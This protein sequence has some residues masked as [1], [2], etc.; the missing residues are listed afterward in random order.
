MLARVVCI[1]LVALLAAAPLPAA[2]GGGGAPK[3]KDEPNAPRKITDSPTFMQ[4]PA[5]TA[6]IVRDG[7]IRGMIFVEVG[8]DIP[9][10]G[11][12]HDAGTLTPRLRDAWT[13]AMM[14]MGM[15]ALSHQRAP[16]PAAVAATLQ[17][18]TD[19]VLGKPGAQV[20]LIH[21]YQKRRI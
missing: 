7:L 9:D 1:V 16:D 20:L 8:L 12:R 14:R 13:S 10:S 18:E 3:P 11:L 5:V 19:R 21:L 6:A 2:A 15:G 4:F 17:A